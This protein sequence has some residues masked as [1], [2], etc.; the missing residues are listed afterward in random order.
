MKF[1]TSFKISAGSGEANPDT[2]RVAVP[3][4]TSIQAGFIRPGGWSETNGSSWRKRPETAFTFNA[5]N[6][7][8]LTTF[9]YR[10]KRS[11]KTS[12]DADNRYSN[13][14]EIKRDVDVSE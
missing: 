4:V 3:G 11:Y 14:Y 8:S 9:K 6:G 1:P 10:Y 5:S 12:A 13:T 7:D 2:G